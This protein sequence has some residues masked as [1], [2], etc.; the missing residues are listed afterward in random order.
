M[1]YQALDVVLPDS[2]DNL[3]RLRSADAQGTLAAS[4]SAIGWMSEP[5]EQRD[6][7]YDPDQ[8]R[9]ENGQWT[10]SGGGSGA[11]SQAVDASPVPAFSPNG[12]YPIYHY[13]YAE[14]LGDILKLGVGQVKDYDPIKGTESLKADGASSWTRD[15]HYAVRGEDSN[16]RLTVDNKQSLGLTTSPNVGVVATDIQGDDLIAAKYEHE[17]LVHGV[18]PPSKITEIAVS[19]AVYADW[20]RLPSLYRGY[21]DKNRKSAEAHEK[22]GKPARAQAARLSADAYERD[23]KFYEDLLR[24]PRLK[25]GLTIR[26]EPYRDNA[27]LK[28]LAA[29]NSSPVELDTAGE[30][31]LLNPRDGGSE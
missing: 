9:D 20:S 16:V 2:E 5:L 29:V 15:P 14:A 31:A 11:S 23:A 19:K 13:T 12:R 27:K 25:V 3:R 17:E 4:D 1:A 22:A 21:A 10:D 26:P 30:D 6:A 28:Q 7:A 8:P 24:D 18:V